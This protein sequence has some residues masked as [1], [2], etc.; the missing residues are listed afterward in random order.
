MKIRMAICAAL[1][2]AVYSV[3]TAANA[4]E[5][6]AQAAY[7]L[8]EYTAMFVVEYEFGYLNASAY[9]PVQAVLGAASGSITEPNLS[10]QLLDESGTPVTNGQTAAVVLSDAA[11]ENGYYVIP[12]GER[13]QF[14]LLVLH[15]SDTALS[16]LELQLTELSNIITKDGEQQ[17]LPVSESV[18]TEYGVAVD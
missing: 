17:Y 9:L 11:L 16:T 8:D 18:L 14:T 12:E 6:T 13:M 2:A 1:C 7:Q 5:S 15:R 10:Y 3:P 4:F